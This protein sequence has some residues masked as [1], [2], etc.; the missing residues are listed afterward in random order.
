MAFPRVF[1][2][3]TY[4][5]LLDARNAIETCLRQLYFQPICFERGGINYDHR[6]P[7]DLSCYDAVKECDMM[8][9]TIGGRYGSLVSSGVDSSNG[10]TINSVTK[11]E[12]LEAIA[13]G[14]KVLTF[15]KESVLNEYYTYRN[16]DKIQRK[17]F[18]PTMVD[19]IAVFDLIHE[20][21][22]LDRNNEIARY[23]NI[24]EI[25]EKIQKDVALLAHK[26]L[27]NDHSDD[28]GADVMVNAF[29]LFYNRRQSGISLKSLSALS[30]VKR[31]HI[32]SLENVKSISPDNPDE[33]PFRSTRKDTLK[34]IED[35]LKCEGQLA[36]GKED[37]MLSHYVNYYYANRGKQPTGQRAVGQQLEIFPK[38]AVVFDFDGTLTYNKSRTTWEMIW[39]ELGYTVNDCAFYHRQFSNGSISHE[40]WCH[41]TCEKFQQ[42][43]LTEEILRKI[44]SNIK[45]V[46]GVKE[47][48]EIFHENNIEI[49]I[50]SGS[51]DQIILNTL[52]EDL[53][54]R[55]T[56]VQANKFSFSKGRLSH[57][58]GTPYDFEGKPTFIEELLRR[59]RFER[60]EVLFVGNSSNDRWVSKSGVTTL[61][62]NPHFT[63]G[64]DEKE[65]V[66]CIR[67]MDSIL[68]I[69]QFIRLD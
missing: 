3:S 13:A 65:W 2:S 24:S 16:Q 42:R 19:N 34:R 43:N 51:I 45:L 28:L 64:N 38:R 57:I 54:R 1:I 21:M 49:H 44:S 22:Q 10:R 35:V 6:K 59:R 20:I 29:K 55:F 41:I 8:I 69:L 46:D 61:C 39:V 40:Q 60:Y 4:V 56:T 32:T 25:I 37:D 23:E 47:L 31:N 48:I 53:Y 66:H 68:E 14:I 9:L 15:I 36:A 58:Y 26:A 30:R 17:F 33:L 11:T 5:D 50:L 67:E 12:Y 63:D 18:K 62:V 7:M 27:K 52:G